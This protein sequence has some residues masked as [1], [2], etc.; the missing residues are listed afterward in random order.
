VDEPNFVDVVSVR[1]RAKDRQLP[2]HMLVGTRPADHADLDVLERRLALEVDRAVLEHEHAVGEDI[3]GASDSAVHPPGEQSPGTDDAPACSAHD[4]SGHQSGCDRRRGNHMWYG[5][6]LIYLALLVTLGV[7]TLRKGH[8][9]L[10][11]F[12]IFFPVLWLV[13]AIMRPA[14]A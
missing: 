11:F 8:G 9:W 3:H 7:I 2:E 14:R 1:Q 5:L 13:G 4:P 12:G 10:F 6:G